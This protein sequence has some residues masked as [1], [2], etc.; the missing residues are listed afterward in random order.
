MAEDENSLKIKEPIFLPVPRTPK[1]IA[2]ELRDMAT[3]ASNEYRSFAYMKPAIRGILIAAA[4]M[5]E[6]QAEKGG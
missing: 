6:D 5:L 4:E 1:A 3:A 2:K